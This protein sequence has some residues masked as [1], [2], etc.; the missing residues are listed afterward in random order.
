MTGCE[1]GLMDNGAGCCCTYST[2]IL[3]DV[4][5]NGL[6]LTDAAGGVQFDMKG[7][8]QSKRIAWTTMQSDD[9]WLGLDR[10]GNGSIDNG[11]ELFGN[12]TP[13]PASAQPNGFRALA[14]I[15]K[16]ENGGNRDGIIDIRDAIF[17][18]LRLW[19]DINHNGI[20]EPG[21][22]HTLPSVDIDSMSLDYKESRR[23]DR[24]GNEFR[25]RAKVEDARHSLVGRWAWDVFLVSSP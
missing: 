5:G 23:K 6:A 24:Y 10:N 2:P 9:A 4:S 17:L 25:Y 22:L 13:Q 8:G 11:I 16:P 19:Q 15:D 18:S 20:S 7:D 21:E 1:E 3:V 14:E 12:L